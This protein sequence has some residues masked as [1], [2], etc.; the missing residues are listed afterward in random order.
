MRKY[1]RHEIA[2]RFDSGRRRGL[3]ISHSAHQL[4]SIVVR[5]EIVQTLVEGRSEA[6]CPLPLVVMK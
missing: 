2:S 5:D 4:R 1:P 6:V 3:T